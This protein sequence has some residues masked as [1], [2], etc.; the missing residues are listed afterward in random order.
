M[1]W[2]ACVPEPMLMLLPLRRVCTANAESRSWLHV[3]HTRHSS[4]VL[5]LMMLLHLG[6]R[7]VLVF[8]STA[9]LQATFNCSAP[10]VLARSSAQVPHSSLSSSN[11]V[12]QMSWR[13]SWSWKRTLPSLQ[14]SQCLS[15]LMLCVIVYRARGVLACENASSMERLFRT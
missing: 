12:G 3:L 10:A 9:L 15:A 14:T 5:L 8:A 13:M 2:I 4:F 1:L 7:L 11:N 6:T